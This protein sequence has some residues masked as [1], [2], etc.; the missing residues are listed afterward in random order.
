MNT[1][2]LLFYICLYTNAVVKYNFKYI[3]NNFF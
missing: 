3:H 1:A 2:W